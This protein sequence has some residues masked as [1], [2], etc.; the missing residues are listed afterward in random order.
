ME[1]DQ[2][3]VVRD[4]PTVYQVP[5]LLEQQKLITLLRARLNL[6][7]M[8]L[9][10]ERVT[11][12]AGL[13]DH[14]KSVVTR[15]HE[16]SIDI[17][18]VGKYVETHDAYLSVVKSLEHSSMHLRRKLNLRWVDAEHLEPQTKATEEDKYNQAW[19]DV[20]SASGIIVPGGFGLRGTEGMMLAS[21]FAREN[22][23]PFLGVCAKLQ[24]D[25]R[26][27]DFTDYLHRFALVSK[28]RPSSLPVT[29]ATC[30]APTRRSSTLRLVTVWSYPCPSLTRRT[31]AARC[32]WDPGR[33]SSKLVVTGLASV[34]STVEA[35]KSRR[36]TVIAM[37]SILSTFH[38]WRRLAFTSSARMRL[39]SGW[40]FLRLRI[41]LTSLVS[42]VL[43]LFGSTV[44]C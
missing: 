32:A 5:L 6:D 23:T 37:K 7:V 21:K 39:A 43:T 20:R 34:L 38:A 13:W 28:R 9:Q 35:R 14:W 40:R 30:R 19:Q 1:V 36:D 44:Q 41:I 29:C 4:M 18:L 22:K 25:D 12:G 17:A 2:I 3:L 10:P 24:A 26:N 16:A 31:W 33:R 27:K 11:K 15:E 8:S 42:I